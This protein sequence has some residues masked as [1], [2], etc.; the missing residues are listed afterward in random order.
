MGTS[1]ISGQIVIQH[2]FISHFSSA[3]FRLCIST[4][5]ISSSLQKFIST[6]RCITNIHQCKSLSTFLHLR[7]HVCISSCANII[8][9]CCIHF[10][11]CYFFKW[12]CPDIKLSII[13]FLSL[14]FTPKIQSE[15][16]TGFIWRV[17]GKTGEIGFAHFAING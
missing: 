15:N 7:M 14:D 10:W 3:F 16:N 2:F 11:Q 1:P 8:L 4:S 9:N 5:H 13:C 17:T 6:F 12:K